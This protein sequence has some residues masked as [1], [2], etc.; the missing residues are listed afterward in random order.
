[1][2]E[3]VDSGH[4]IPIQVVSTEGCV[5]AAPTVERVRQAAAELGVKIALAEVRVE[6]QEE[7]D[8]LRMLG[9]PTVQINGLD[10]DPS[11]RG[12][13]QYGFT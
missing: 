9:S 4:A 8:A 10:L 7:A 5:N 12:E 6:T 1:M 2:A 11:L 13:T 3:A